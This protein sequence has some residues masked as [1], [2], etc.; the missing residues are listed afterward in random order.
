MKKLAY[1][2][3]IAITAMSVTGCV[4]VSIGKKGTREI[5]TT[6][7]ATD[8]PPQISET[9]P[10]PI[11][12]AVIKL[13]SED[14]VPFFKAVFSL[15]EEQFDQLNKNEAVDTASYFQSLRD[16]RTLMEKTF[17]KFFAD[18]LL[19]KLK[20]QNIKLDI[21]LPKKSQIN[22][23]V[24]DASG[25]LQ[26]VEIT[27]ARQLGNEMLYEIAVATSNKVTPY[28]EFAKKYVWS[29]DVGY[30]VIGAPSQAKGLWGL[31]QHSDDKT[32]A[33]AQGEGV[34]DAIKLMSHYWISVKP[35]KGEKDF[36]ITGMRQA[37]NVEIDQLNKKKLDNTDYI[38]RVPYYTK[39]SQEQTK[40]LNQ[41]VKIMMTRPVETYRYYEK[42]YG[43]SFELTKQFW[44]DLSL[45]NQITLDEET[46]Q[47]AF[48]LDINPYKNG[49]IK[50]NFDNSKMVIKPSIYS[51]QFQPAFIV[52]IPIETLNNN[53]ETIYYTYK[54]Y[55]GMEGNRVETIQFLKLE[56]LTKEEYE[57]GLVE[58][59]PL[60]Q[61]PGQSQEGTSTPQGQ[62]TEQPQQSQS[63]EVAPPSTDAE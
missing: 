31:E 39:V 37:G 52:S 35:G 54:Y 46:Y 16:Y 41:L 23:Y 36:K 38:E 49:I 59:V 29:D 17:S 2:G 24:T 9:S 43:T 44:G 55:I 42:V 4:E 33:Y 58:E 53:N 6:T 18:E 21:D 12:E 7:T 30:Y 1:F 32:Y 22:D 62:V 15:S 27:S 28:N 5:Q 47:T 40:T 14:F 45:A 61:A 8:T 3:L 10:A 51:S 50:L 57:Q 20:T 48:S 25:T 26:T 34:V 11:E 56:E 63:T 13:E 19:N 60:E